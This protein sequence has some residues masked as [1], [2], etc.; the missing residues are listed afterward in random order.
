M[1]EIMTH[2]TAKKAI[3]PTTWLGEMRALLWLGVPMAAAQFI[4]FFVYFIDTAMIG[5]IS[6]ED[7]A[8][9][10][11]G[12][13]IYFV[14]W[15]LGSGPVMAVS[16]LVSQAMG[17]NLE[18]TRDARRSVR[19]VIWMIF[20]MTPI[21]VLLLSFT[22]E[23]LLILGQDPSVSAKAGKYVMA[24]AIGLPFA[25]ATMALRNFLAA[26]EKTLIPLVLVIIGTAANGFLNYLFIFGNF[27]FPRLELVGAGI[28]SSL[29]YIFSF[30]LFVLYIRWDKRANS[31]QL[32][33]NFWRPDWERFKEIIKL[34][35]P[36]SL[37]TTFEGMLF[38]AGLIV[39]G[40][41]GVLE[42]AAYQIALNV[43]AMAF[44]LPYG[45]SMA[46]SVRI[47]LAKGAGDKA[48]SRRAAS[49][50]IIASILAIMILAIPITLFPEFT[51]SLYLNFGEAKNAE[52][53]ALVVGFLPIA[54][55]FM[56]FDS[57]QVA[58]NQLLR[59]LKDVNWPMIYTGF[60]YWVIGFPVAYI[61]ALKTEVGANGV[62]YGLMAGLIAAAI[63]LGGRL[64]SQLR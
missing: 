56:L 55:A 46:G 23:V 43:A 25:M 8:A 16:P 32:F 4:Q 12:S 6:P 17:A 40:L 47:G 15:M 10:G 33:K 3:L 39:M 38:N 61:L 35:W 14:L 30:F 64:F 49:T 51:T 22:E 41:L 13:V 11:L 31:F 42:A 2:N 21:I 54:T 26:L 60:S 18:D 57:I 29:A 37:T 27:G 45:M 53:I 62:W 48:A 5:R 52:V 9:A 36:I 7:V 58:A 24:L 50:T 63:L 19:M 34:G 20:L 28:A 44:M 59:G 1:S